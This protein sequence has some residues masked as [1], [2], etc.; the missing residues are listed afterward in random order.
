MKCGVTGRA[1]TGLHDLLLAADL[2][3]EIDLN[4]YFHIKVF[5]W[6]DL[7]VEINPRWLAEHRSHS[8]RCCTEI[9]KAL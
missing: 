6:K 2:I 7:N 3:V 8:A 5:L 4:V 1:Q 9:T